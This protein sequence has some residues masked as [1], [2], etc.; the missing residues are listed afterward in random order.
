MG[1]EENR[2]VVT[3]YFATVGSGEAGAVQAAVER[4]GDDVVWHL[5]ASLP[6]GGS[7]EG[8]TA[9]LEMLNAEEGMALYQPGS[10][11]VRAEAMIAD[12]HFV[13]VPLV[14]EAVTRH[15]EAY[16]NRYVFVYRIEEGRIAEVWENLDT[17]YLDRMIYQRTSSP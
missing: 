1:A 12:E 5:P 2:Q 13:V 15:G 7:Y 16:E 9:V 11:R 14:L 8:K 3:E 10:M 6:N 4:F 17:L